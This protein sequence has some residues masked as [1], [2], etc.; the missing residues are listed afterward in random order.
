MIMAIYKRAFAILMKKPFRLWGISLLGTFLAGLAGVAFGIIPI[1]GLAI[2]ILFEVSLTMIF[3]RGYRGEENPRAVDLFETFKDWATIKRVLCGMGWMMLWIFLWGLIPIVGIIFAI[4]RTYE[5]RL[6]P[7][8]LMLEP[9][10]K[11]T[12]AIKLSKERTQGWKGKMFGADIL[13]VIAIYVVMLILALLIRIPV[14]GILFGIIEV[15]FMICAFALLPL[16]IGLVQAAFYEEIQ[17]WGTYPGREAYAPPKKA[18]APG[19]YQGYDPSQQYGQQYGQYDPQQYGQPYPP[20]GYDPQQGYPPQGY[21]PYPPQGYD[22]QQGYPPQGY[23]PYPPQGYDPQQGYQPYPPQGYQ[24]YPQQGYQPPQPAAPAP[25]APAPDAWQQ[26][27]Q[28]PVPPE[29][30]AQEPPQE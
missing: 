5:Y 21:Q 14:A 20:Q 24:P 4:I 25:E 23:Q 27:P 12:E 15:V 2:A 1:I 28:D 3:L 19:A 13:I 17:K 26:P 18:P 7:Y 6:T 8:I 22:P 11:P 30:P 29:A 9:D 10:V 16:F